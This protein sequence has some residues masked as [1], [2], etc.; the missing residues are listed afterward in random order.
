MAKRPKK[1]PKPPA[2]PAYPPPIHPFD[3]KAHYPYASR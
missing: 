2:P 3:D 1:P